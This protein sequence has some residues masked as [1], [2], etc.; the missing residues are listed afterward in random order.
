MRTQKSCPAGNQG[1][2]PIGVGA[3]S[4]F[5]GLEFQNIDISTHTLPLRPYALHTL[6][7]AIALPGDVPENVT[8]LP[9]L[10]NRHS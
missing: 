3:P 1:A 2:A 9:L 4:A 7:P 6:P 10:R 8:N 5:P